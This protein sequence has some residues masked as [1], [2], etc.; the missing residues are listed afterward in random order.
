MSFRS[1]RRASERP[2]PIDKVRK[3]TVKMKTL[4]RFACQR[5]IAN[6]CWKVAPNGS[7]S[8]ISTFKVCQFESETQTVTAIKAYTKIRIRIIVGERMIGDRRYSE[9]RRLCGA[10]VLAANVGCNTVAAGCGSPLSVG[11]AGDFIVSS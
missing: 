6:I 8:V 11:C 9:N 10:F 3:R 5:G 2:S 1:K 4:R 7:R